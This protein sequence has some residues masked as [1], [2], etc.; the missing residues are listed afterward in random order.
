MPAPPSVLEHPLDMAVRAEHA[1]AI[2]GSD[3]DRAA[4]IRA[5]LADRGHR[6]RGESVPTEVSAAIREL[7]GRWRDVWKADVG[8]LF[9]RCWMR[10]GFV[11]HVIAGPEQWIEH[12]AA[13]VDAHPVNHLS[14]M[15]PTGVDAIA[16]MAALERI[17]ALDLFGRMTEDEVLA[18][19]RAPALSGLWWLRV[20]A[21][22][23]GE[24]VLHAIAEHLTELRYL[25]FSGNAVNPHLQEGVDW[26]GALVHVSVDPI[27]H[28]LRERY[29]DRPW[30]GGSSFPPHDP[31]TVFPRGDQR[32]M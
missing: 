30:I 24:S 23:L 8:P 12:G 28:E 25:D 13:V 21:I 9:R 3:P 20:G 10:G 31:F 15:D 2:E 14:L 29:G 17:R 16:A 22:G 32:A 5:Q 19:V 1:D 11:E 27:V 26:G 7:G 4:F 6:L 18:L